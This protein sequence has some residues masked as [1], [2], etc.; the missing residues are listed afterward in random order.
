MGIVT[1]SADEIRNKLW[2]EYKLRPLGSTSFTP[3]EAAISLVHNQGV[4][5]IANSKIDDSCPEKS[6]VYAEGCNP[7]C[8]EEWYNTSRS[9]VGGDDF[10]QELPPEWFESLLITDTQTLSLSITENDISLAK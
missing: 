7:S 10:S 5:L 9:L 1:F 6:I 8:D 3:S 4:Y 2:P